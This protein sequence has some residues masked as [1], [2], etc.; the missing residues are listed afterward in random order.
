[1]VASN[2]AR[3]A[4][5]A[6]SLPETSSVDIEAWGG[7][8]AFKVRKKVF[9][10]ATPTGTTICLKLPLS[11]AEALVAGDESVTPMK[12]NLGKHGWIEAQLRPDEK[13]KARWREVTEWIRTS[14]SLVAP[15]SL[16]KLMNDPSE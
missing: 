14:Y 12:F 8:S 10:Y 11:E 2:L 9:L 16:V 1:M 13:D 6:A 3:L 4:E 5:I 7:E 15:K